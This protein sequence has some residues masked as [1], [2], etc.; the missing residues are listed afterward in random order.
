[1]RKIGVIAHLN[2]K[3]SRGER[4]V[5]NCWSSYLLSFITAVIKVLK[6]YFS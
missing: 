4:E 6:D 1:M 3:L 5:S 2:Q